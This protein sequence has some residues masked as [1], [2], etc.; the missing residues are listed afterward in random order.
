MKLKD[1]YR[2]FDLIAKARMGSGLTT[3]E[4]AE[5]DLLQRQSEKELAVEMQP[6]FDYIAG[7]AKGLEKRSEK[8]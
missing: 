6:S 7:I 3:D 2:R 1:N 8:Q 4:R 5:L